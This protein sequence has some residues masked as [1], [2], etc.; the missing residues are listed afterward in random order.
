MTK[1]YNV[2]QYGMAKQLESKFKIEEALEKITDSLSNS[3]KENKRNSIKNNVV[4]RAM[5]IDNR[6][7]TLK[8]YDIFK[9]ASI[10]N[11]QIF[12]VYPSLNNIYNYFIEITKIM[13]KLG[14]PI[15]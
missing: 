2:S 5:T 10:I 7:I 13:I 14:I 12:V 8:K 11:D 15:S 9:I 3:L 4:Y 1:V 6:P